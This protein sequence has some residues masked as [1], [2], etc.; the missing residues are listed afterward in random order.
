V[1][2]GVPNNSIVGGIVA[3]AIGGAVEGALTA[4]VIGI[5]KSITSGVVGGAIGGTVGSLLAVVAENCGVPS[6]IASVASGVISGIAGYVGGA[7]I[8]GL[9]IADKIAGGAIGGMVGWGCIRMANGAGRVSDVFGWALD[10][11]IG[12]AGGRAARIV[13]LGFGTSLGMIFAIPVVTMAAKALCKRIAK[14]F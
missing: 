8:D 2:A 11:A 13:G 12:L 14:C 9:P 10:T 4:V 7:A 3:G 5:P 1:A 6:S